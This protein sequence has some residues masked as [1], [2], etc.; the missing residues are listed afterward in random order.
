MTTAADGRMVYLK[1]GHVIGMMLPLHPDIEARWRAG[2]LTRVTAEGEPWQGDQYDVLPE[3]PVSD[4]AADTTTPTTSEPATA[5]DTTTSNPADPQ[6][7]RP[8]GNASRADWAAYAV[9][10]GAA[11]E[12]EAATLT[13]DELAELTTP[14]EM[15]PTVPGE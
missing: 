13:R 4:N 12:A 9:Q 7:P 1:E 5:P 8:R 6:P 15:K 11:T 2:F 3:P 10:L 14:P